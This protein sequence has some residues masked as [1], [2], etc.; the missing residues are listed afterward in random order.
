MFELIL[1]TENFK[2]MVQEAKHPLESSDLSLHVDLQ[3]SSEDAVID[4]TS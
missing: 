1:G 3:I 2:T 4:N